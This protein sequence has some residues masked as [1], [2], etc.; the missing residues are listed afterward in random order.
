MDA[1]AVTKINKETQGEICH[2]WE[3]GWHWQ[4]LIE[5]YKQH[6]QSIKNLKSSGVTSAETYTDEYAQNEPG[7]KLLALQ[8]VCAN[9]QATFFLIP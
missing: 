3:V 6:V 2:A 9:F 7:T 8:R 5:L 4:N 1:W